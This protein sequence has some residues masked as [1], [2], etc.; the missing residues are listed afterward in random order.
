MIDIWRFKVAVECNTPLATHDEYDFWHVSLLLE[1]ISILRSIFV[2]PWSE[3]KTNFVYEVSVKLT[4]NLENS[5]EAVVV[6]YIIE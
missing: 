4:T 6:N 3:P 1:H 5:F 2:L